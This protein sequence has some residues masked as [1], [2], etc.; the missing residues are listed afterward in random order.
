MPEH[1]PD[2]VRARLQE[3]ARSLRAA[4]HLEPEAQQELADLMEELAGVVALAPTADQTTRLAEH[5]AQL[6]QA[7]H[8]QHDEGLL[9]A[10]KKKLEQ[11]ALRAEEEAPL[12]TGIVRRLIDTLANLGI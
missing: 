8:Q 12:A 4:G 1:T 11:S 7:L 3:L 9:A 10:A 2:Q 6:A 5:A